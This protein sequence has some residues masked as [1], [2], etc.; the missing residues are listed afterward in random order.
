[1]VGFDF[2]RIAGRQYRPKT[3]HSAMKAVEA[4]VLPVEAFI[5][6][7]T[8]VKPLAEEPYNF[9]EIESMLSRENLDL[10]TTVTLVEIFR[11]LIKSSDQEKALFAAE[12]MN[13]IEGRYNQTIEMRK[14]ELRHEKRPKTLVELARLYYEYSELH[15][16]VATMK[17][18]YLREAHRYIRMLPDN[19]EADTETVRLIVMIYVELGL[20]EEALL[21]LEQFGNRKDETAFL[22]LRAEVEFRRRNFITVFQICTWL[23]QRQ[24]Q[25]DH[26]QKLLIAHWLGHE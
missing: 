1:M 12:S 8:S 24:D 26:E 5:S 20:Y 14:E 3:P 18:F 15:R 23:L 16:Q 11:R 10:S 4:Q 9:L 7:G 19:L 6:M 2:F 13:L 22:F 25:L 17:D 21:T